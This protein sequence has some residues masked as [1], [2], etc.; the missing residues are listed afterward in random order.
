V[1]LIKQDSPNLVR[2]AP[3]QFWQQPHSQLFEEGPSLSLGHYALVIQFHFYH[4]LLP[5]FD[6]APPSAP[7]SCT[8]SSSP[9]AVCLHTSDK[10]QIEKEELSQKGFHCC[11]PLVSLLDYTVDAG[12]D[13]HR[14]LLNSASQPLILAG[15]M[16]LSMFIIGTMSSSMADGDFKYLSFST[17]SFCCC[18]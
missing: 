13:H 4:L 12:V 10:E 3:Q 17:F 16:S 1:N 9:S 11:P 18:F 8:L 6:L 15:I 14:S 5:L 7:S 2:L